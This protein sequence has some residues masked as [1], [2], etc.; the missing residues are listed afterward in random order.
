MFIYIC[1]YYRDAL[2]PCGGTHPYS[3]PGEVG[4][5]RRRL[6]HSNHGTCR[7]ISS[8]FCFGRTQWIFHP[9]S[10]AV[11]DLAGTMEWWWQDGRQL[12]LILCSSIYEIP[13]WI[14]QG[15]SMPY[16]LLRRVKGRRFFSKE[17][18]LTMT[19][20]FISWVLSLVLFLVI[21]FIFTELLKFVQRVTWICIWNY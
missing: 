12:R 4:H 5:G 9:A 21:V 3:S 11:G 18:Y 16:L 6:V 20:Q 10:Q 7:F 13:I 2:W 1:V 14:R 8:Q 15:P 17:T 19:L